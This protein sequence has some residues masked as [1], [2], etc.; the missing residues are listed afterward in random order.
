M[1]SVILLSR[2]HWKAPV[3]EKGETLLRLELNCEVTEFQDASG[4][5]QRTILCVFFVFVTSTVISIG[6]RCTAWW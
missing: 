2:G 6:F 4:L 3:F 5:K 1:H